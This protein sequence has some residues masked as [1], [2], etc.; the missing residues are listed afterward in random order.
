MTFTYLVSKN[1]RKLRVHFVVVATL[2]FIGI[3]AIHPHAASAATYSDTGTLS[4]GGTWANT[5]TFTDP[6][7]TATFDVTNTNYQAS[8]SDPHC[9]QTDS[10][11]W[12]GVDDVNGYNCW[13]TFNFVATDCDY[14]TSLNNSL[15]AFTPSSVAA[16]KGVTWTWRSSRCGPTNSVYPTPANPN[17][18]CPNVSTVTI[19]FSAPVSNA[20]LH[21]GNLGG[22]GNFP[23]SRKTYGF[24]KKFDMTLYSKWTLTSGQDI[25]ML[26]GENTT[27][28]TLDNNTIRN[29]YIPQG[30][31]ARPGVGE[32]VYNEQ[33]CRNKNGSGSGSFLILGT[34]ST[35][36]FNID[37]GFSLVNYGWT[38]PTTS[39]LVDSWFLPNGNSI[40]EGVTVQISFYKYQLSYNLGGGTGTTPSTVTGLN[41]GAATTL[42]NGTGFTKTGYTFAGWNCDN[43]I[44]A[45][46]AGSTATQPA[47]DV[48]CTAR[49][50]AVA[51]SISLPATGVDANPTLQIAIL[52]L[53][54][55]FVWLLVSHGVQR[56]RF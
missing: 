33:T 20:I 48:I 27:N 53:M 14:Q 38:E 36:T 40:P 35:I 55:G 21:I 41:Q 1:L 13:D 28:I 34:Y 44:G 23:A 31:G 19:Q 45:K 16:T 52:A 25:T 29:K 54:I 7:V 6:N 42:A 10:C 46:A 15:A 17:I 24:D 56:R 11:G 9:M 22:S 5:L 4:S 43:S 49:W 18:N 50:T 32:C 30:V 2:L 8:T 37:L 12:W 26:S 51:L 39:A 3:G 47:A